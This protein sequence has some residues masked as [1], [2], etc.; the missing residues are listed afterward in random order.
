VHVA[1]FILPFVSPKAGCRWKGIYLEGH[2]ALPLFLRYSGIDFK[3]TGHFFRRF[4]KKLPEQKISRVLFP[5]AKLRV[6]IIYLGPLSP[7][8]S[9]DLP[10]S[11][12]SPLAQDD[13]FTKGS[14]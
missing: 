10:G 4:K 13:T 5:S 6:M 8:D 9:S 1:G 14:G 7:K 3:S 12:P 2:S 11:D